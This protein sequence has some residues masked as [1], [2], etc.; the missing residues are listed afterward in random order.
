M[1]ASFSPLALGHQI[2]RAGPG[3]LCLQDLLSFPLI[4]EH[5][6][7]QREYMTI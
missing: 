2:L 5:R 3:V 7:H 6:Q 1:G 4:Y